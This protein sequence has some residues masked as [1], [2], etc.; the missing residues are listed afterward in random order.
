MNFF[1]LRNARTNGVNSLKHYDPQAL[2]RNDDES[3]YRRQGRKWARMKKCA[4]WNSQYGQK[5]RQSLGVFALGVGAVEAITDGVH[6]GE[7]GVASA[8][9]VPEV[10]VPHVGG[11]AEAVPAE[12]K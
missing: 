10:V 7:D 5:V 1:K 9:R 2:C 4:R 8:V 3:D 12:D 11:V 6:A